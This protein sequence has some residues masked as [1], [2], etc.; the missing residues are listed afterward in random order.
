MWLLYWDLL[1]LH[2]SRNKQ[3]LFLPQ[4]Y[5]P[6]GIDRAEVPEVDCVV[7]T[8]VQLLNHTLW[9]NGRSVSAP[10]SVILSTTVCIFPPLGLLQSRVI[11]NINQ[12]FDQ[13]KKEK[14]NNIKKN[15]ARQD[16]RFSMSD[17]IYNSHAYMCWILR[18]TLKIVYIYI[19]C[20]P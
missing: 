18:Q 16:L 10:T 14:Y 12:I 4:Y 6:V 19:Y 3:F 17:L 1:F 15:N 20:H 8:S 2:L 5:M 11:P 9:C 7:C 13:L